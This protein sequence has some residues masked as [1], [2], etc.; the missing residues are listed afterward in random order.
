MREDYSLI[1]KLVLVGLQDLDLGEGMITSLLT[2]GRN[3]P[4]ASLKGY[5]GLLEKPNEKIF[6]GAV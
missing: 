1:E 2:S 4:M 5:C 6:Q 3:E